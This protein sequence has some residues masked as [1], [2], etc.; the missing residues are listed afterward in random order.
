MRKLLLT[1]ILVG[2][3]CPVAHVIAA[4]PPSA[5]VAATLQ[6]MRQEE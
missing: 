2:A 4:E 3:T 6:Y 5:E 1:C